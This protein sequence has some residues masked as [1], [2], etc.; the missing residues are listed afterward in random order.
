MI[1]RLWFG[2]FG[3]GECRFLVGSGVIGICCGCVKWR[4]WVKIGRRV[5]IFIVFMCIVIIF[6]WMKMSGDFI[7]VCE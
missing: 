7:A 3:V 5:C 1:L 6:E 2:Q 4:R